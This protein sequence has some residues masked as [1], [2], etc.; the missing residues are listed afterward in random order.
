[1]TEEQIGG[2]VFIIVIGAIA[3]YFG[4]KSGSGFMLNWLRSRK[5]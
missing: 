1:M 2:L 5:Q 4:R 3:Y